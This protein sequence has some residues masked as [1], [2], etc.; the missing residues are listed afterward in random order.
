MNGDYSNATEPRAWHAYRLLDKLSTHQ[1]P[2]PLSRVTMADRFEKNVATLRERLPPRLLKPTVGVVC[3]SGLSTLANSLRD[4]VIVPYNDLEGFGTSTGTIL[5]NLLS[6]E[7]DSN[8]LEWPNSA[9]AQ[10]RARIW[11]CR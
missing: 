8:R 3:G 9:R 6:C 10:E 5:I 2:H 1:L 4:V 7:I 11:I